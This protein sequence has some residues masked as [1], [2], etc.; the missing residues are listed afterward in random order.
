MHDAGFMISCM[1][2]DHHARS[3]CV[4]HDHHASKLVGQSLRYTGKPPQLLLANCREELLPGRAIFRRR[5]HAMAT[6]GAVPKKTAH[7]FR[8]PGRCEDRKKRLCVS[9]A[10]RIA[11]RR[12]K[13]KNVDFC[14][15]VDPR[16]SWRIP[17]SFCVVA[18][19]TAYRRIGCRIS[20]FL[21]FFFLSRRIS[22]RIP[23]SITF[24]I[25]RQKHWIV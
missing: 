24:H 1:M 14:V 13:Q 17:C 18:H 15:S 21:C 3:S 4:T 22:G 16:I 5:T 9:V 11:W 20:D 19:I 8:P 7:N 12:P 23:K 2:Y 25:F 6:Y 10:P